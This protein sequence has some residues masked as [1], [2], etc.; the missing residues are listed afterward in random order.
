[1]GGDESRHVGAPILFTRSTRDQA[2]PVGSVDAAA[3]ILRMTAKEL[4]L[5]EAPHWSEHDAE[6]ALRAVGHEHAPDQQRREIDAAIV[7]SYT[8]MPQEDLGASW[9]ARQSIREEPWDRAR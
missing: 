4:L 9:S 1:M 7:E 8:Q 6:V 3:K 5:Q 2:R